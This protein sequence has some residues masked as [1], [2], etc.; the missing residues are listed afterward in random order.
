MSTYIKE[1]LIIV[2]IENKKCQRCSKLKTPVEV[3]SDK[4]IIFLEEL[5]TSNSPRQIDNPK[6][7]ALVKGT[8]F[9]DVT[10]KN[11]FKVSLLD[12]VICENCSSG[13]SESIKSTFTVSRY[14]NKP[15]SVL[16]IIF[17]RGSYDSTNLV[18]TKNELKVA[19]PS[20]YLFKQ[21]SIN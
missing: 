11:Y 15:P 6:F 4:L 9:L 5:P 21:P 2:E 20:E 13:G 18:A 3:I 7:T 16:K 10:I 8:A 1:F 12:D 14:L 19:I 17:Q